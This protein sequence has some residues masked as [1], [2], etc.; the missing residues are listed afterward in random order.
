MNRILKNVIIIFSLFLNV[1]LLVSFFSIRVSSD[2]LLK[3]IEFSE[4]EIFQILDRERLGYNDID[5]VERCLGKVILVLPEGICMG[6]SEMLF[7]Q[8]D[9]L[10]EYQKKNLVVVV[11]L[12]QRRQFDIYNHSMYGLENVI[13]SSDFLAFVFS[14]PILFYRINLLSIIQDFGKIT[15]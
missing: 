8:I 11:P 5:G 3:E 12:M 14:E 10:P 13:Y 7:L 9:S 6:C 1:L 4:K 15:T 2:R